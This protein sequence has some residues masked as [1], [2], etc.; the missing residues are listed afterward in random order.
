[1]D[2]TRQ[3]EESCLVFVEVRLIQSVNLTG[4]CALKRVPVVK[5]SLRYS[6][7]L[8]SGLNAL[9]DDSA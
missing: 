4:G 9:V 3:D 7:S 8:L 5:K 6:V 2:N 1:M